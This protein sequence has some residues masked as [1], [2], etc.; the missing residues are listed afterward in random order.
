MAGLAFVPGLAV[1]VVGAEVAVA[2]G[3]AVA[4]AEVARSPDE[5]DAGGSDALRFAK[6]PPASASSGSGHA[7]V[8]LAATAN[9]PNTRLRCWS[10][11]SANWLIF[12]VVRRGQ[13]GVFGGEGEG[14]DV[15]G[16]A[17]AGVVTDSK[18]TTHR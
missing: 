15:V 2:D 8:V 16:L 7:G 4:V 10:I 12:L 3:G 6:S 1:G 17:A 14:F 13:A 11:C 18:A 5:A 9:S